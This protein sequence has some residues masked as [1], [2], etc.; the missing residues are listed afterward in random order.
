MVST[1][2]SAEGSNL[3]AMQ[4]LEITSDPQITEL[5]IDSDYELPSA[6]AAITPLISV[7]GAPVL[8]ADVKGA[9]L[10]IQVP[11][12]AFREDGI[13]P[14]TATYMFSEGSWHGNDAYGYGC[15]VAPVHVPGN[16]TIISMYGSLYDMDESYNATVALWRK[17]LYANFDAT[18][19]GSV[20]TN[21]IS[22]SIQ[23]PGDDTIIDGEV[24]NSGYTYFLTTCLQRTKHKLYSVRLYYTL[25]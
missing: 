16:A 11:A 13:N 1:S 10:L 25:N 24:S 2:V 19:L 4:A 6:M 17:A 15:M 8:T 22:Y 18:V 9:G 3:A 20:S 23:N 14:G 7:N 21:G 12:A 5:E